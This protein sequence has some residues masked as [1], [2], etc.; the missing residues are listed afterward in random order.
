MRPSKLYAIFWMVVMSVMCI[1]IS[2]WSFTVADSI[3]TYTYAVALS[4]SSVYCLFWTCVTI[5]EAI[6]DFRKNKEKK[7]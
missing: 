5:G 6:K 3:V 2:A 1:S 7:K 4:V